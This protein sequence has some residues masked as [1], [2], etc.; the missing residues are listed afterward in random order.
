MTVLKKGKYKNTKNKKKLMKFLLLIE[1]ERK[2]K[3]KK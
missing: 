1:K 2:T 3:D